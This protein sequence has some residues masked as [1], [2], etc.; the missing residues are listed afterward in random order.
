MINNET[1]E[2]GLKLPDRKGS[3]SD[4]ASLF[5]SFQ[6]LGFEHE[7]LS[8]ASFEEMK[9]KFE[10]SKTKSLLCLKVPFKKN[11]KCVGLKYI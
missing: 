3:S 7:L 9:E 10:E 8:D 2:S 6:E 1:F 11:N 4:A 5:Q